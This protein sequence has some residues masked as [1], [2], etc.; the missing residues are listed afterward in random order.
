VVRLFAPVYVL[1]VKDNF[2]REVYPDAPYD[3]FLVQVLLLWVGIQT[4]LLV[5][6][7][8]YGARFMIP[9]RFLPPKFDYSRPL[10]ASLLPPGSGL[11]ISNEDEDD[12]VP[13]VNNSTDIASPIG[14]HSTTA[15]TRNRM[16]GNRLSLSTRSGKDAVPQRNCSTAPLFVALECSICYDAIDPRKRHDYMLAPCNHLYHRQCLVNWMD[17]KMECPICRTELPAL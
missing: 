3:T 8:K 11:E 13:E 16:R 2:L 15:T 4:F 6:Q 10:P 1:A 7:N 12:Q 17:V 5:G 9:A 14:R